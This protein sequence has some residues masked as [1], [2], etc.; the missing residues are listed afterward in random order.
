MRGLQVLVVDDEPLAR[1]RLAR[2]LA[3]L[4][5]YEM[6]GEADNGLQAVAACQQLHPDIVLMDI[7]MPSMD[8]LEASRLIM[9]EEEIPAIIFCTAYDDYALAAF[10]SQ[11]IG[12][13]LKPARKENLHKALKRAQRPH[14]AQM[15]RLKAAAGS[16]RMHLSASTHEGVALIPVIEVRLL[17]AEQKYVTACHPGG[18]LLLEDSL[19]DLEIEFPDDFVRIHRNALVNLN[20]VQGLEK[21]DDGSVAVCL[22]G[23]ERRGQISRRHLAPIRKLLRDI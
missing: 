8:G 5:G 17:V 7:R 15:S 10:E 4:D 19:R 3:E 14:R 21:S 22:S 16:R 1:K 23:I 20:H 6:V 12:Y 18:E 13:L 9:A 2:L 11:A